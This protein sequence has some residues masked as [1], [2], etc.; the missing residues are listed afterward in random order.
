MTSARCSAA[1]VVVPLTN[2]TRSWTSSDWM[3]AKSLMIR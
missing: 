1:F 2:S 3:R